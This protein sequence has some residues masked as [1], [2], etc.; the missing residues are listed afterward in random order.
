M[1]ARVDRPVGRAATAGVRLRRMADR[2][3]LTELADGV[4]AWLQPGGETGVA[5]AG[6]VV[7]D[8]GLTVI[9]TLMVR[10]QWEPFAAAVDG[11]RPP[12]AAHASS[13]TRTSTTS[14]APRRS[15]TAAI[16]GTPATSDALDQPMPIDAYKAFMPAFAEEFDDLAELGTRPVTHLVD[17]AAQLTPRIELLPATGHTAGDLHGARRRRRR[18]LRRRPLLLRR[19]AARVPGRPRG[20]GRHARRGRR[21]R[22]RDRARPRA[23]RRR[24]PRC[25][26]C[27][28]YLRA[29]VAANGDPHAIAAGPVGHAGSTAT[30]DAIN[31]ERAALLAAGDDEIPPSMLKAIGI[32]LTVGRGPGDL[33]RRVAAYISGAR[34][35]KN[36]DPQPQARRAPR[37]VTR[38]LDDWSTMFHL[39]PRGPAADR[40]EAAACVPIAQAHLRDVR[41]RRLPHRVLRRRQRV[42]ATRRAR[43]GRGPST[44]SFVDPDARARRRASGS[45]TCPRSCTCARTRTLVDRGRGLGP[46]R[47]AAGGQ[48]DRQGDGLERAHGGRRRRPAAH[49]RLARLTCV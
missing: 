36:P 34:M 40:P 5:N 24:A 20:V 14:A 2:P 10:S 42:I 6:V 44:S 41:R 16:Y 25:A 13:P 19:D 21:A 1:P 47:V 22:R 38:T 4:Y 15:P 39:V 3:T 23:G 28:R 9:D 49:P 32:E 12:G 35:A 26:T 46:A 8:D 30:R 29:C 11:A 31:V 45:R 27:R 48:R 7:D 37:V 17:G 18:V 43:R 33:R